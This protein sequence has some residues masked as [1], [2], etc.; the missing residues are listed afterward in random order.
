MKRSQLILAAA[1][2]VSLATF[3]IQS[4]AQY[5]YSLIGGSDVY[6]LLLVAQQNPS[7]QVELTKVF[8]VNVVPPTNSAMSDVDSGRAQAE[9]MTTYECVIYANHDAQSIKHIQV[10]FS[11]V[12][13]AGKTLLQDPLDL[14]DTVASGASLGTF[15]IPY[16]GTCRTSSARI[17]RNVASYYPTGESVTISA[18]LTEVD[19]ADGTSWHASQATPSAAPE[20]TP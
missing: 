16:A 20:P 8:L 2:A 10:V 3:P 12:S 6:S 13:A 5:A 4:S 17:D 18:A 9:A 1:S 7:S 15:P 14:S 11:Y 19:Y